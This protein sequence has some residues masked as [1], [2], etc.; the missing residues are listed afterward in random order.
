[1]DA[2]SC[3]HNV[4]EIGEIEMESLFDITRMT[5]GVVVVV[6]RGHR[7]RAESPVSSV[8]RSHVVVFACLLLGLW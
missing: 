4:L 2:N 7:L 5:T 3:G 6:I 1:M 8:T